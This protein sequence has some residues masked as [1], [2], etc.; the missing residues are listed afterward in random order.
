M[1]DPNIELIKEYL[2]RYNKD[3]MVSWIIMKFRGDRLKGWK[4]L[5]IVAM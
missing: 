3:L 2:S 1:K 5:M 4:L